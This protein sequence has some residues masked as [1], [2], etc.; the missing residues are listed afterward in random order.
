MKM[1]RNEFWESFPVRQDHRCLCTIGG[2]MG[3]YQG[4]EMQLH[5]NT[6]FLGC[7]MCVFTRIRNLIVVD[8]QVP[9]L[10][11]SARMWVEAVQE[12]GLA[13]AL[14]KGGSKVQ[15]TSFTLTDPL[16]V[17]KADSFVAAFPSP[18]MRI[19][20]GIEFQEVIFLKL[21]LDKLVYKYCSDCRE[22]IALTSSKG[23][24]FIL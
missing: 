6:W 11:G 15:R 20:Y 12:T 10:D 22:M 23:L 1:A 9:L 8:H 21:Q 18:K 14:D 16:F 5:S 2:F 19:S 3:V 4:Q 13:F 24:L 7:F 17:S